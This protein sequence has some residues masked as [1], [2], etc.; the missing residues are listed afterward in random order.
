MWGEQWTSDFSKPSDPVS[1]SLRLKKVICYGLDN[2]SVQWGEM[3]DELHL[4]VEV[5]R[6]FS[7]WQ[8]VTSGVP[9]GIN[10]GSSTV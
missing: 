10:T 3:A 2:R 6:S 9:Q 4:R 5:N 1:H 8:S 7:N